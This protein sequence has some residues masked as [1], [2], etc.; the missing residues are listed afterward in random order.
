MIPDDVKFWPAQGNPYWKE[1]FDFDLPDQPM[2]NFYDYDL[3]G[4]YDPC[5]G[6]YP[7]QFD[8]DCNLHYHDGWLVIPAEINYFV[9]NDAGRPHSLSGPAFLGMEY[10]VNAYAYTTDNDLNNTTLFTYKTIYKGINYLWDYCFGLWIDPDLGCYLD[11][12]FGFD[13]ARNMAFIYNE[14]ETDGSQADFC[15]GTNTYGDEIPMIGIDF[16]KGFR[17]PKVY[18]RDENGNI[19]ADSLGNPVLLDPTP[20]TGEYDTLIY[21]QVKSFTYFGNGG[22]GS[23]YPMTGPERSKEES[24]YYYLTC[25]WTDGTPFTYGGNGYNIDVPDP[26]CIAYPDAPNDPDGWS[27]CTAPPG[28][29]DRRLMMSSTPMLLS[30]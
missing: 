3:D 9:L 20:F 11:D 15:Y 29:G 10:H 2:A 18:G 17:I 24:F 5:K 22:F 21:S 30:P 26:Y 23:E 13:V 7:L 25:R 12:Y 1:N 4:I 8:H 28:L 19:L 27:M 16:L 14:D 6:D